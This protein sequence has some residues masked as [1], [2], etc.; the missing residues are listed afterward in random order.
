MF[1]DNRCIISSIL[2][3]LPDLS[4]TLRALVDINQRYDVIGER[5]GDRRGETK[6]TLGKV[7]FLSF[8]K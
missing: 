5:L 7:E 8:M 1:C 3:I 6:E 4:E 2:I